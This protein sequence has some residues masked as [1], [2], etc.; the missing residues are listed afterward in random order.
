MVHATQGQKLYLGKLSVL[1]C[2]YFSQIRG[3]SN[4]GNG[5]VEKKRTYD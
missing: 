4:N 2:F 1:L 3:N 5:S